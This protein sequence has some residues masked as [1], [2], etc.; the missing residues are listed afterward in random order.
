MTIVPPRNTLDTASSPYLRHHADNPI[1]WHEW[2][3]EAIATAKEENKLLF[4]SVGYSTCHWCHVMAREAFSDHDTAAFINAHFI[5]IK[6]DRETRPDIDQFL[7]RFIQAQSGNGGWP[8]NVFLTADLRPIYALTYLPAKEHRGMPS[9]LSVARKVHDYMTTHTEEMPHFNAHE[10]LPQTVPPDS[11]KKVL[12]SAYDRTH[13]GFGHGQK[14]PPHATLLY[15]LYHISAT[16]DDELASACRHTLDIMAK[17]GLHDHLQGG[18]FRY[19]VDRQWT[20]P[21]FEKMLYDNAMA[22]WYYALAARVFDD[23][24]YAE[25][26]HK[27]VRFLEETCLINGLYATA[28][29]ADTEGVEGGTYLWSR[30]EIQSLLSAEQFAV[31][32]AAYDLPAHGNYEGRIHLTRTTT[33]PCEDAEEILLAAR[34]TRAQPFR[35]DKILC[36]DNALVACGLIQAARFLDQPAWEKRAEEM[37]EQLWKL[38]WNGTRLAHATYEGVLQE[39]SFLYDAAA[40]FLA[41]TLLYE[42]DA[43]WEDKM[44]T[45]DLYVQS[46]R[47]GESWYESRS[48]DFLSV[49]AS[50]YDHPVPS[51]VSLALLAS[52]RAAILRGKVLEKGPYFSPHHADFANI[53]ALCADGLFHY[54]HA[55]EAP[56]WK[57]MPVNAIYCRSTDEMDCYRGACHPLVLPLKD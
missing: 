12:L 23:K 5:A 34:R 28:Y 50:H 13:G 1:W 38:F 17:R 29:D 19:C 4:I 45:L 35:D 6:V 40:L 36:G 48:T 54:I 14:F 41:A 43:S 49:S 32:S 8:L 24:A 18:F 22:L 30:E 2:S 37:V 39:E 56:S 16:P 25:V 44:T 33:N 15:M 42:T 27:I 52:T 9:F 53:A 20:I 10:S 57:Q 46:F 11:L 55:P 31:F 47:E 51:S 26:A 3:S 21:H 7:M